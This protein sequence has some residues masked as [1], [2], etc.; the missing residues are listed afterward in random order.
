[1]WR[2]MNVCSTSTSV[3]KVVCD[4]PAE[5]FET[6]ASNRFMGLVASPVLDHVP[7]MNWICD[8]NSLALEVQGVA[9]TPHLNGEQIA[10]A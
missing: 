3:L 9:V 5:K 7:R 10:L 6:A 2:T 1:M 4:G 8:R